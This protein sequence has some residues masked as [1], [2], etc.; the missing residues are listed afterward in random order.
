M[1]GW[2]VWIGNEPNRARIIDLLDRIG[3]TGA[4][5]VMPST[6]TRGDYL[7]VLPPSTSRRRGRI[8]SVHVRSGR[9]EFQN[10]SWARLRDKSGFDRLDAGDKAAR[11]LDTDAD[12]DA[13]MRAFNHEV[14]ST[15]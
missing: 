6:A 14:N 2:Q 15:R 5:V 9:V 4:A 1:A 3:N 7:N 12:V 10:G 11:T 8:C 13:V